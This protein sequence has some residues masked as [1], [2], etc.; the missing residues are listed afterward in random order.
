MVDCYDIDRLLEEEVVLSINDFMCKESYQKDDRLKKI[1]G[2]Q[3]H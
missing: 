2:L 1:S 3:V